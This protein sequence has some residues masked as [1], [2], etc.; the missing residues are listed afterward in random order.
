MSKLDSTSANQIVPQS[1]FQPNVEQLERAQA[2]QRFTRLYVYLPLGI[3]SGLLILVVLFLLYLA[4][5]APKAGTRLFLSGLADFV[6]V[7]MLIPLV[8]VFGLVMTAGIG[9][10]VYYRFVLDE[11]ERPIPPAPPHG[12]IRTLLWRVDGLLLQTM[13][14]VDTAVNQITKPVIKF[15]GWIAYFESWIKSI[16]HVLLRR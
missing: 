13:P 3:L 11:A 5:F 8:T 2:A 9:G 6:L 12:R 14:K 16:K 15:N 7:L 4:I 1:G 10:Y